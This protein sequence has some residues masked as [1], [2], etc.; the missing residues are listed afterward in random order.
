MG[1][2]T[3][4]FLAAAVTIGI[5]I[6]LHLFQRH[7]TRRVS[8]PALRYLARTERDHARTIRFRQLLLLLLRVATLLLVVGAGARLFFGGRGTAHPPTAVVLIVDN[9]LSSGLVVGESRVLDQMKALAGSVLDAAGDEDRFW[10]L[11]AGEPWR[12]ALPGSAADVRGML[13]ELDPSD[14]AGD[15][16]SA[17][18]R[19]A[20]LLRTASQEHREIHLLSDLQVSGLTGDFVPDPDIP[21]VAWTG[22]ELMNAN[23]GLTRVVVGGGLPPLQGQRTLVTIEAHGG[24]PGGAEDPASTEPIPVRLVVDERIR[25]A[26]TVPPGS[27]TSVELPASGLGWVQGYVD[28]DPDALRADDRRFFAFQSRP[29]SRVATSGRPGV[30]LEQALTV[31]DEAGR[32]VPG[33]AGSSDALISSEGEGLDQVA[34]GRAVIIVPPADPILLPALNRRLSE[35]G[36]PW[37]YEARSAQGEAELSGRR[38]PA[39]L[40][41]VTVRQW[42]GLSLTADAGVA[43]ETRVEVAGQPWLVEGID[44]RDRRY[45]LLASPMSPEASSLPVSSAMLPFVEWAVSEWAGAGSGPLSYQA[46]DHL[47]A[48]SGATHVRF[49][50]GIDYEIDGTRTVRGT[51][52]AGFYAF[53][54]QDSTISVVAVNPAAAES[55]LTRPDDNALER[56]L[57]EDAVFVDREAAWDRAVFRARQ[58]PELWW[59][60]L[61]VACILLV[62]ES[63][64]A[65]AGRIESGSSRS[66]VRAPEAT[67]DA[68]A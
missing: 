14:G 24:G 47:P 3:P 4:F 37:R 11:P 46:G 60:L 2:L 35:A 23:R 45:L 43:P 22:T 28:S 10:I 26:A 16:D 38:M 12:P 54:E 39:A 68:R 64:V 30:F 56:L 59:P 8:F 57:G 65:A 51:G 27:G 7:E 40:E 61:L 53:R 58:G 33:G 9:S 63:L 1:A 20:E 62:V 29:P 21:V 18:R 67:V 52:T 13:D 19:A 15:L 31:L 5:P 36:I 42:Y 66:Q 6:F 17:L 41:G 55:D 44:A 25:A 49:P 34:A 48:P 50:S 32:M